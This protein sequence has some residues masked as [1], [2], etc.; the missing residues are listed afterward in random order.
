MFNAINL[1]LIDAGIALKD[2]MIASNT[3]FV[4]GKALIDLNY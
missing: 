3:A 4:K 1:G 2:F